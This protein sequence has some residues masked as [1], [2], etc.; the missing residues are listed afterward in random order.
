[1]C[2]Y[3]SLAK[4]NKGKIHR[5][6]KC[7]SYT[8]AFNN[9]VMTFNKTGFLNFKS[10]VSECYDVNIKCACNQFRRDIYFNTKLEGM[11][12]LFSTKEVGELLMLLQEAEISDFEFA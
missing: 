9:I 4:T 5:C 7:D 10:N 11:Q 1:M 12:L 2:Q 6:L 8:L 3:K